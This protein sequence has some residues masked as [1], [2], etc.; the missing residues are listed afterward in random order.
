MIV[1]VIANDNGSKC[2]SRKYKESI[3]LIDTGEKY[4]ATYFSA[5]IASIK[6]INIGLIFSIR[7]NLK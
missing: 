5:K 1:L 7:K 3:S 2:A 4:T 6:V